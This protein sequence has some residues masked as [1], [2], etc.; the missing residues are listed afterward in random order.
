[1][2]AH[3][4]LDEAKVD[5]ARFDTSEGS[6]PQFNSGRDRPDRVRR[7]ADWVRRMPGPD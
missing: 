6:K 5:E 3:A 4:T 2:L 1:M 7:V